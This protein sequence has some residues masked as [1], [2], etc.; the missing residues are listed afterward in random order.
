MVEHQA[1]REYPHRVKITRHRH[2][3]LER[4]KLGGA[5]K[6]RSL[7]GSTVAYVVNVSHR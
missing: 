2:E 3:L 7:S 6:Q 4:V 5:V 1:V